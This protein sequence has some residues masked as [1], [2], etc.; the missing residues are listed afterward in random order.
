MGQTGSNEI[1]WSNQT[2]NVTLQ[3][4][5]TE[6]F[7]RGELEF[8]LIHAKQAAKICD[9]ETMNLYLHKASTEAKA[10][11]WLIDG[12]VDQVMEYFRRR[13]K[14]RIQQSLFTAN[15]AAQAGDEETMQRW[16]RLAQ[17]DASAIGVDLTQQLAGIQA[18]HPEE[19]TKSR[20]EDYLRMANQCAQNGDEVNMQMCI[21]NA[22][23]HAKRLGVTLKVK[24]IRV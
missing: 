12:Q 24:I 5:N 22:T 19:L 20:A 6:E 7:H 16:T 18:V 14:A 1:D 13:M 2:V 9:Q 3:L 23:N 11:N 21:Q 10:I 4:G 17:N 8:H 15:E